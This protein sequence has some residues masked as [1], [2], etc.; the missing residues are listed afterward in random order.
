MAETLAHRLEVALHAATEA[1]VS[2]LKHFAQS[3]LRV[4]TK[5]D[6]TPVTVA[7][8]EAER[9]IRDII[10]HACPGDT[11]M[12]EEHDTQ[13]GD[14]EYT[15]IIDPID[16]TF[17]FVRGV[18][19]YTTLIGLERAGEMVAG[20]IHLP[21]LSETVYAARGTGA[22]HRLGNNQP[23][24]ARVSKTASLGNAVFNTTSFDYYKQTG[25]ESSHDR[26]LRAV[27]HSRG[28]SDAYAAVLLA[29]GRI[30]V[31]VE[32]VVQP[33]DIAAL[34][35]I[36]QEAGGECTD[37]RG[38]TSIQ[39]GHCVLTNGHLHDEAIELLSIPT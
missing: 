10:A 23:I 36:V 11:I 7:D 6:G 3:A 21:A 16:G 34:F 19:L 15:W 17:S 32:P 1:G 5:A 8:R 30:D 33:W 35:P 13:I 27:G 39:S 37:W 20:V 31:L 26:L 18:P 12:G 25:T 38:A 29:T 9:Q 2:T 24:Q 14:N 22:W 28:W 4:E